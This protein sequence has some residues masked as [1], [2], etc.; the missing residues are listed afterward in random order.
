M[1]IYSRKGDTVDNQYPVS[2]MVR[3]AAVTA[4]HGGN[5]D[6]R[7]TARVVDEARRCSLVRSGRRK[8]SRDE[9]PNAIDRIDASLDWI[10]LSS[11]DPAF[12]T[13]LHLVLRSSSVPYPSTY[14]STHPP[15]SSPEPDAA[16]LPRLCLRL[17]TN[18]TLPIFYGIF[19]P[20]RLRLLAA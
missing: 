8:Q 4:L 1:A 2:A 19:P 7:C 16:S 13:S 18:P 11:F 3:C 17:E 20:I 14:P 5:S 6:A 9:T 12:L 15:S 10:C